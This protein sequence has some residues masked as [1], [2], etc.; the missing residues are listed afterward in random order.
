MLQDKLF[1]LRDRHVPR[2]KRRHFYGKKGNFAIDK[3]IQ[4]SLKEKHRLYR[5][6]IRSIGKIS[7]H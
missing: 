2:V 1:E 5:K 3:V 7:E 4:Q 6:W